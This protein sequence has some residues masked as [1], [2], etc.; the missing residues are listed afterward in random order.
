MGFC[1]YFRHAHESDGGA[2]T[3]SPFSRNLSMSLIGTDITLFLMAARLWKTELGTLI[4]KKKELNTLSLF[5]VH[6][7][8]IKTKS[9]SLLS[10]SLVNYLILEA[11]LRSLA[12]AEVWESSLFSGEDEFSNSLAKWLLLTLLL[13]IVLCAS[14][15]DH[16]YCKILLRVCVCV[17]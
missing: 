1:P 11:I 16:V 8:W 14:S 6:A 12:M 2:L 15:D 17:F 5:S 10:L 3:W 9:L 4:R 7:D 13:F